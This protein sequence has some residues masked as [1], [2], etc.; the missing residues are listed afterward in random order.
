MNAHLSSLCWPI[1][2]LQSGVEALVERSDLR[3][4]MSADLPSQPPVDSTEALSDWLQM[5]GAHMGLEVSPVSIR[6]QDVG[7]LVSNS[8]PAI[9]L[10][11]ST[12]SFLLII[13][14]QR[15]RVSVLTPDLEV[16]TQDRS[17]LTDAIFFAFTSGAEKSAESILDAVALSGHRRDHALKNLTIELQ[18]GAPVFAGW[19]IGEPA[20]ASVLAQ[21]RA[22]RIPSRI[23]LTLV[24]YFAYYLL[25]V[26]GWWLIG[27]KVLDGQLDVGLLVGWSILIVSM[28]PLQVFGTWVRGQLV[29]SAGTILKRIMHSGALR[30]D[31]NET[32]RQGA[33]I[34]LGRVVES[35][36]VES[37]AVSGGL[38]SALAIVQL[39]ISLAVLSLGAAAGVLMSG[40]V[41]ML[42]V[43][44]FLAYLHYKKQ[45]VW[46]EQRLTITHDLVEKMVGYRTR[47]M[48]LSEDS[49][50]SD[51]DDLLRNYYT[52]SR[53]LDNSAVA[54]ALVPRVWLLLAFASMAPVLLL[55][56]SSLG[57]IGVAIGGILLGYQAMEAFVSG[58][59]NNVSVLLAFR[60]VAPIYA[61]A[62]AAEAVGSVVSPPVSADKDQARGP[63]IDIRNLGYSYP[64]RTRQAL[65][66]VNFRVFNGDRIVI[67]GR[68]GSGKSTLVALMA[69]LYQPS[70]GLILMNGLDWPTLGPV[71]WRKRVVLVP[72]FH[73]NYIVA[74][75]LAFNLFL[76][77]DWPPTPEQFAH[78][79]TICEEL[80]LGDL[81]QRMPAGLMQLVGET[82]WRLSHGERSRI[83][84]ARALLQQPQVLII[85]E[86]FGALD[87]EN[88]DRVMKYVVERAETLIVI[89]H[90]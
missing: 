62:Q 14:C 4:V 88:F 42:L 35:E 12:Q 65:R 32:R 46:V 68:S 20:S 74:D 15:E 63:A 25:V 19:I 18:S 53:L 17:E 79:Q 77:S 31:L 57:A 41:L 6:L 82:G 36:I 61:A 37:L 72:Q 80:G 11:E 23:A 10:L 64:G 73:E 44:L 45:K 81:I 90:P 43:T 38:F 58:M 51:D 40:L 54:L 7:S 69:G 34:L 29:I 71:T 84:V 56:S 13:G 55:G 26:A 1:S 49:W 78:A 27:A 39:A 16:T 70:N 85:D 21:A 87:P 28:A 89:S 76:G 3:T 5:S 8:G 59:A 47:L 75:S 60:K 24:T 52:K 9:V 33:G 83:Y 22:K 86:S 50:Y 66:D 67:E 48:Q 2:S 30:L